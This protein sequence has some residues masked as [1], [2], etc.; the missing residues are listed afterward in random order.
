MTSKGDAGYR[1]AP[2]SRRDKGERSAAV[3][4][5]GVLSRHHDND[6]EIVGLTMAL[7]K[8]P[9]SFRLAAHAE[10]RRAFLEDGFADFPGPDVINYRCSDGGPSRQALLLIVQCENFIFD[11]FYVPVRRRRLIPVIGRAYFSPTEDYA[12][13]LN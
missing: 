3:R 4:R 13:M 11:L 6:D 12:L 2:I 9:V 7:L 5:G 8:L 10:F 1:C